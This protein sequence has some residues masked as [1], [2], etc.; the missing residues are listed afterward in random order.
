M[1]GEDELMD[2]YGLYDPYEDDQSENGNV[3]IDFR[4]VELIRSKL[5]GAGQL[6]FKHELFY[7][8]PPFLSYPN[9]P[10]CSTVSTSLYP[11]LYSI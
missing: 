10:I 2:S 6:L 3:D 11:P 4:E 9:Q 1:I 5:P 7:A 8:S